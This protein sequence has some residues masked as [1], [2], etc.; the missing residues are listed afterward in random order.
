MKIWNCYI[1]VVDDDSESSLRLS[2]ANGSGS[3]SRGSASRQLHESI[4][5][6]IDVK[7]PFQPDDE[8][9]IYVVC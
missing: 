4:D 3:D 1:Y 6:L 2:E 8:Q 9:G 7:L 5:Y